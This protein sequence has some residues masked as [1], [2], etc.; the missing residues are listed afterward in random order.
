MTR[1]LKFIE[2]TEDSDVDAVIELLNQVID[3]LADG[4]D[5]N[6]GLVVGS[7][8]LGQWMMEGQAIHEYKLVRSRNGSE[9][10]SAIRDLLGDG[11]DLYA[12]TVSYQGLYLQWMCREK[13][14]DGQ[15]PARRILSRLSVP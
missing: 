12:L 3:A 1:A 11:W 4:Y 13:G 6:Q 7:H 5:L 15:R 2:A 10:Y 14:V 9:L 8:S